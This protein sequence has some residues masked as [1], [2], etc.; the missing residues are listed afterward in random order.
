MKIERSALE[1]LPCTGAGVDCDALISI[2]SEPLGVGYF[3]DPWSF[4]G[5]LLLACSCLC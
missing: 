3:N 4:E 5:E 1:V 2:S